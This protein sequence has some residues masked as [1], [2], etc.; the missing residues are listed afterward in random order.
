MPRKPK[1]SETAKEAVVRILRSGGSRT[2]AAKHVG[3]DRSTLYRTTK[4][5]RAF[6]DKLTAAE[7]DGKLLLIGYIVKAAQKDWR[8]AAW[9]LERKH[10]DEYARRGP[11]SITPVQLSEALL[12]I[13]T[14][15]QEALPVKYRA[16]VGTAVKA[17][18]DDLKKIQD[19]EK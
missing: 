7:A 5:D 16:R 11:D 17:I 10:W 18:L 9:M 13:V 12:Q 4:R 15:I 6:R 3:V 8:A 1:I 14:K 2:D 19:L